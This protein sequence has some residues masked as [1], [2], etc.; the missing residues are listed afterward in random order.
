MKKLLIIFSIICVFGCSNESYN[1]EGLIEKNEILFRPNEELPFNGIGFLLYP[2]G[3]KKFEAQ[4]AEGVANGYYKSWFEDGQV[5]EEGEFRNGK[6]A[7][8]WVSWHK[9]GQKKSE[10]LCKN[11][12]RINTWKFWHDN[13]QLSDEI[14][15]LNGLQQGLS[16]GWF[17]NGNLA[18]ECMFH[19]DHVDNT[20]VS[21]TWHKNGNKAEEIYPIN[22]SR[23]RY[24]SWYADGKKHFEEI[25]YSNDS[26]YIGMGYVHNYRSFSVGSV[27]NGEKSRIVWDQNGNIIDNK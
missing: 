7:G 11:G 6:E 27:D 22:G 20:L 14:S 1:I 21:T 13:G 9:N 5:R 16:K 24:T 18:Y 12:K 10:G 26:R 15:Y 2:N 4:Y 25:W 8:K 3:K 23:I 19:R 17:E